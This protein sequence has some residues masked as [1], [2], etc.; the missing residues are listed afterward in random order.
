M[1]KQTKKQID[2]SID[3][4]TDRQTGRQPNSYIRKQAHR[5]TGGER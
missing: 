1:D 2:K 4:H 3:Q 5:W